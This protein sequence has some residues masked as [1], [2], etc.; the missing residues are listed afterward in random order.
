MNVRV[1]EFMTDSLT[2][3]PLGSRVVL[4]D[5]L[6][7][8]IG[9]K[10]LV[11]LILEA[12]EDSN[13]GTPEREDIG[14]VDLTFRPAMML[15]LLVYCY[16]TGLYGSIDIQVAT[17]NDQMV[18]YLCARSYP[19]FG[20]VASFRRYHRQRIAGCLTAVL[21]RVWELRFRGEDAR[22]IRGGVG[23]SLAQWIGLGS[24][25]DFRRDAEERIVRAVRA[26][27]MAMDV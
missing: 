20:E 13:A 6:S 2:T 25:P 17:Q 15:T 27:S 8:Y 1:F 21:G 23:T 9:K 10:T 12:I 24:T 19:D 3:N 26:D 16:A 22:P 4:P 11:K 18:R 7:L 5:D 14:E